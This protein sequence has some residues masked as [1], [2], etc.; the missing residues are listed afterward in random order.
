MAERKVYSA[1]SKLEVVRLMQQTDRTIAQIADDLR[2]ERPFSK[3][4]SEVD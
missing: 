4:C 3:L 2:I 1:N